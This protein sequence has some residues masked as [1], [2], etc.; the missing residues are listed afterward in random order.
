M[1]SVEVVIGKLPRKARNRKG[2]KSGGEEKEQ[3]G[4]GEGKEKGEG[5]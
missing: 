5:V 1:G 3:K 2:K 4:L